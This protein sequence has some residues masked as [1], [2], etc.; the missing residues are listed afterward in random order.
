M[1]GQGLVSWFRGDAQWPL[2]CGCLGP[3]GHCRQKMFEIIAL[4]SVR[5]DA[6]CLKE[7]NVS[8]RCSFI[9]S[10]RTALKKT[11]NLKSLLGF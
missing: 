10:L 1:R 11:I 3:L 4:K 6:L 2:K 9:V 7:D 5:S 8:S